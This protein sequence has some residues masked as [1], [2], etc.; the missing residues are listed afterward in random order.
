VFPS[1][2][3][4]I[5]KLRILDGVEF[6]EAPTFTAL[7]TDYLED[8]EYRA[9][10]LFLA[11]E[12]GGGRRHTGHRRLSQAAMGRS[13]P[14]QGQAWWPQVIYYYLSADAQ[15]WVMTLYDKDEMADLSAAE[16]RALKTALEA[17]L[18]RRAARRRLR[19]K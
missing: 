19:R 3:T 8:D 5:R 9:L 12:S 10:Q 6:L 7:V 14:T 11:E 18:A 13:A 2:R 16:K 1:S 15:I 4:F 17:E